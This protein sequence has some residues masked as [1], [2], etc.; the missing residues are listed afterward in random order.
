MTYRITM[1]IVFCALLIAGCGETRRPIAGP[2]S[3]APTT[4][5]T[6][7]ATQSAIAD[8]AN[9]VATG[10]K[11][12]A[13][14]AKEAI[15]QQDRAELH[16]GLRWEVLAGVLIMAMGAGVAWYLG[17]KLGGGIAVVGAVVTFGAM[18]VRVIEPYMDYIVWTAIAVGVIGAAIHFRKYI[19]ATF[20]M[21]HGTEHLASGGVKDLI[22][23]IRSR[24]PGVITR[25]KAIL[26]H[27]PTAVSQT[28]TTNLP[29]KG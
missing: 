25:L 18:T 23:K 4:T 8:D 2:L 13:N 27:A 21:A 7:A 22:G 28:I 29:P 1:I 6:S 5:T 17:P 20:H 14:G 9:A 11:A 24:G 15:K 26:H 19:S 3:T 10:N 12:A 16:G